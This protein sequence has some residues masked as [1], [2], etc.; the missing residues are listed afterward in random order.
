MLLLLLLSLWAPFSLLSLL[1]AVVVVSSD[2]AASAILTSE[3]AIVVWEGP[4]CGNLKFGDV[5]VLE[6]GELEDAEQKK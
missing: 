1:V 2:G 6:G 3:S 4:Y 5:R